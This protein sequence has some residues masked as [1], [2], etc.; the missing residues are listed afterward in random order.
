FNLRAE[1]DSLILIYNGHETA[2]ERQ[3]KDAFFCG[4]P[5]FPLFPLRFGRDKGAV[6]EAFYGSDWYVNER[7][8]GPKQFEFPREWDAYPG[9]Y[10]TS[11]RHHINFRIALRKGKLWLIN[12]GG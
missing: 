9:H 12:P 5:D 7:Y 4:H 6:V 3:G 1:K 2:L 8:A 11:S 10:R